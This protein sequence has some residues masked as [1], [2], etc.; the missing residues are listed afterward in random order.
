VSG[1]VKLVCASGS[2]DLIPE[3]IRAVESLGPDLPVVVM[4][5]F[6]APAGEWIPY[7]LSWS[8][9]DNE[10]LLEARLKGR[11]VA[12]AAI[13]LQPNM[14]YWPLRRL[15][16]RRQ[17]YGLLVFNENL[18]HFSLRPSS[19]LQMIRHAWWRTGNWFR[20]Q[21][22][23]GGKGYTW[24]WR[25]AHPVEGF[26][27][28]VLY[29]LA[30]RAGRLRRFPVAPPLP[31]PEPLPA[32]LSVVIPSRNGRE[33]L[34]TCL[35]RV[36]AEQPGQVIV[37]DNGSDDGTAAWLN[38]EYPS[39]EVEV[40]AG[41]LSFAAA[42]NRG[43]AR[44][45]HAHVCLLN[46]DM[47]IEPGFFLA[48][49]Q[50]FNDVP[51]LFASTAQIF[52]PPGQRR[53]ETGKAIMRRR[54]SPRD[55]LPWCVEPVSG[56]D[57]SWVLY[58]SG[59]CSLYDTAKLRALGGLDEIYA[60]AYVEDLDLGFRAWRQGW[61]SVYAAGARVEHRHRATTSRYLTAADLRFALEVN[62]MKFLVRGFGDPALFARWWFEGVYR[63][64]LFACDD[65]QYLPMLRALRSA[66][67]WERALP[68][69]AFPERS[70]LDL[71]DGRVSLFP[72]HRR[73]GQ[74]VV[75]VASC[76]LPFPLSHGGAVRMFN[77]MRR[78]ADAYDQ[79]LIAFAPRAEP[80]PRELLEICAEVIV[81]QSTGSHDRPLTA[82]PD[83]VEEFDQ[84]A[85]R[86]ALRMAIR[87]WRPEIAQLEFTQMA[88]YARDCAPART[89]LVE[90]DITL[91][92]YGQLLRQGPDWELER[93]YRKW[94]AFERQAWRDVD[95]VIT[96]SE[97]D[98]QLVEAAR[99]EQVRNGVDLERFQ[100]SPR[101]PQPRRLLFIGSFAHLPNVLALDW[102]LRE[103]WPHLADLDVTLHV[104]AGKNPEVFL[105]RYRDKAQPRLDQPGI[106]CEAFVP[107]VRGAYEQAT[108]V[109]APLLASAGTNI[110]IM[111]AMAMGKAIVSTP[112]GLN[113][114]ELRVGEDVLVASS[115]PGMAQQ[116][117]H[118]IENPDLR[119]RLEA[120]ARATAERDFDWNAIA[121][122]QA[123]IY[124]SL[125]PKMA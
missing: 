85:F 8:L 104:I 35:P 111:E 106:E 59:G 17:R 82:R 105:A 63:L 92:L 115:G 101:E 58:G 5:E 51:G 56:E 109:I 32:G 78:A 110:K 47:L 97:K 103:V 84:P 98:R 121:R 62:F 70:I 87:K 44:A 114:L 55:F 40:H 54:Q 50:P 117:R 67:Q 83:V 20:W 42:V 36:M 108:L 79:V 28:P 22:S 10:R 26:R 43:V 7:H 71:T 2:E 3:L 66:P 91:D 52:F 77:L 13:L 116:I 48:L 65:K 31:P 69:A 23:P 15:G 16:W 53:E 120:A 39:V 112:G 93:E 107:D 45:R 25:L 1:A 80:V 89:I 11:T 38:A 122:Q 19:A 102:F 76:Y 14:P 41:P 81:I 96:M 118:V 30:Q 4:S 33:L 46:N 37:I 123:E 6:P 125:R 57:Q 61:P 88:V 113:G 18:H 9:A 68:P 24:L 74:P 100:P 73:R 86:E 64:N 29:R 99:V 72:G 27:R 21:F 60:P 34:A 90:H 12:L 95:C 94:E 119:R 124:E 49:R 75:L